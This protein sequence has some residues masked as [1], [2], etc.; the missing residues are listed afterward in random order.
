MV[1]HASAAVADLARCLAD[2]EARLDGIVAALVDALVIIDERGVIETVNPAAE[3]MFGYRASELVGCNVKV[4]MP[5]PWRDEHDGYL[6]SYLATGRARIIGIGRQVQALR[7][8]RS[9][10][11]AEIAVGEVQ[12]PGGRRFIGL[13]RDIS[14]RVATEQ[15]LEGRE[16]Q[17]RQLFEGAP[18]A[19]L[20]C[21]ADGA[22][23]AANP[24]SRALLAGGGPVAGC[25]DDYVHPDDRAPARA[26]RTEL[27]AGTAPT[28]A[29][30]LRLHV[31]G[32][33]TVHVSA[34]FGRVCLEG[35]DA[36]LVV[37]L[38]DRS[39]QVRAEDEARAHRER[40]AHVGRLSTVGEM[41][42]G[43]AH[44]INQPLTAIA[45]YARACQRLVAAG[46][47]DQVPD[48]L[49]QIAAQAE[50]AGEIIRR[51]RGFVRRREDRMASIDL[52]EELRAVLRLAEVDARAHRTSIILSVEPALPR[53]NADGIQIQ[54]V[55]L[56]LVRN[57][58]EA[59]EGVPQP[60][61]VVEVETRCSGGE[62]VE[63]VIRDRGPGLGE[64]ARR[65]LYT[66]FFTTK[67]AGMGLGLS[68]S[69]SIIEAHGGRLWHDPEARCGAA[70]H[71]RLPAAWPP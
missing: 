51:L 2:T 66:P 68:I 8:D 48:A 31:C 60:E 49:A 53:V 19:I 7:R 21:H 41:A 36:R 62:F 58:V 9:A 38:V 23:R 12:L 67:A 27:L 10:F 40:L 47:A 37:H 1:E 22:I 13:M 32:G 44:E 24:A 3:R 35:G 57:A 11:P 55:V 64:E 18:V 43:L 42:S 5:R 63:V 34:H 59:M 25:I 45:T 26:A 33:R 14:D 61:R 17:L 20:D 52:N 39:E 4:L 50:R 70:F 29:V 71:F 30:D 16:Q 56:N 15:A 6:R 69:Q 28:R 65:M 54:Q 46:G